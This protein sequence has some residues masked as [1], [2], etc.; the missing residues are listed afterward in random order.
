MTPYTVSSPLRAPLTSQAAFIDT[1]GTFRPEIITR[2]AERFGLD[3][4]AVLGNI[5][6]ARAHTSEHQAG[7]CMGCVHALIHM[8][9]S[10]DCWVWPVSVWAWALSG[11]QH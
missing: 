5:V 6:V 4:E 11:N 3:P 10:C 2:V 8:R 7:G 1:E 9:W